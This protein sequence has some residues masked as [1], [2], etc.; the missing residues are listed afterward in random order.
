MIRGEVIFFLLVC[1]IVT[2]YSDDYLKIIRKID[3]KHQPVR[4]FLKLIIRLPAQ[5]FY[6]FMELPHD[7]IMTRP[8][9]SCKNIKI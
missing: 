6:N 4:T 2:M 7:L 8:D 9:Y 3:L 1:I 5:L